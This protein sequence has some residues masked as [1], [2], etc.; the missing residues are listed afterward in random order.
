MLLVM[1]QPDYRKLFL[2]I[3][4]L[5]SSISYS[6]CLC[7]EIKFKLQLKDDVSHYSIKVDY[8]PEFILIKNWRKFNEYEVKGRTVNFQYETQGGVD[9]LVFVLKNNETNENMKVTVLNMT[10]DNPYFIDMTTFTM[11]DYLFDWKKINE[12]QRKFPT[13]I[14]IKCKKIKFYQLQLRSIKELK[15]NNFVINKIKPLKLKY[16][17]RK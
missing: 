10:Y 4:I 14:L 6:Q 16:F 5:L 9:S 15:D 1:E 17:K 13:K 7:S 8:A 12:C 3:I 2:L 11:G